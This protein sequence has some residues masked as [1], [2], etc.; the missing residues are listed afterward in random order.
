M[1]V[2]ENRM[3]RDKILFWVM[4]VCALLTL[5][6]AIKQAYAEEELFCPVDHPECYPFDFREELERA[7]LLDASCASISSRGSSDRQRRIR[8]W[9][10]EAIQVIVGRRAKSII[11]IVPTDGG[12]YGFAHFQPPNDLG[13]SWME[14]YESDPN[15]DEC[16]LTDDF[17]LNSDWV[18]DTQDILYSR[19]SVTIQLTA[20]RAGIDRAIYAAQANGW[21]TRQLTIAAALANSTGESGFISIAEASNWDPEETLVAYIAQRPDSR[22][23]QRR[24]ERLRDYL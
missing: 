14:H 17:H 10:L 13:L 12:A 1:Q 23:R 6:L 15:I 19:Y 11:D 4:I 18:S 16:I 5:L 24:A 9:E 21:S 2:M 7:H 22:H 20:W 8:D 3:S